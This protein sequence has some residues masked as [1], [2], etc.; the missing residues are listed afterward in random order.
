LRL[1]R[2]DEPEI[3]PLWVRPADRIFTA[4][5]LRRT[6][7]DLPSAGAYR[8]CG[9]VDVLN[10]DVEVPHRYGDRRRLT[11]DSANPDAIGENEAIFAHLAHR[12]CAFLAPAE[13]AFVEVDRAVLVGAVQLVPA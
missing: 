4:R 12:H 11:H 3:S 10:A 6:V 9:S 7:H 2:A 13:V 1:A 5:N 8:F